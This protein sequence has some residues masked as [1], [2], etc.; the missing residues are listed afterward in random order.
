MMNQIVVVV[1][2]QDIDQDGVAHLLVLVEEGQD[3][4]ELEDHLLEMKSLKDIKLKE[5]KEG[6]RLLFEN[7]NSLSK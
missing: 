6:P 3:V 7:I 5:T 2:S 4:L 1:V